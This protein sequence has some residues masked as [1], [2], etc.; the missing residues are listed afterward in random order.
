MSGRLSV[1]MQQ[2]PEAWAEQYLRDLLD[3]RVSLTFGPGLPDRPTYE[4]LIAGLPAEREL[5][6]S[7]RLRALIIPW[8]GLPQ[9]TA[10]ALSSRPNIGVHNIHHN[11]APAAE[12]AVA[13]MLAAAKS[14]VPVDR[15]L[16]RSDWSPRYEPDMSVTLYGKT[17]LVLG[18]GAIGRR[19]G[20]ACRGLGMS[21][22]AVRKHPERTPAGPDEILPAGALAEALPRADVLLIALPHTGATRGLIGEAEIG[23]LGED[24]VLVNVARGPVVD[25]EALYR[26][27]E[28]RS[29]RAAGLDVWYAYPSSE[30]ERTCTPPSRFPFG[31]L[32]NVVLS[33]HRAGAFAVREVEEARMAALAELLN[34]AASGQP[35]PHPVDLLEGY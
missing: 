22:V 7:P 33:P 16:R 11:A 35:M 29:I 21:V 20:A 26:A 10:R 1:H 8:A 32:D 27:L 17:A 28:S 15:R 18:Y 19:V 2:R 31:D 23:A 6:A 30:E 12:L 14:L 24:C 4:I 13:L 9:A 25:E 3:A 34:A 5:D